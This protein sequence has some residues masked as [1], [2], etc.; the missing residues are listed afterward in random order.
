MILGLIPTQYVE[1]IDPDTSGW[2]V[3]PNGRA[4]QLARGSRP[5]DIGQPQSNRL[6]RGENIDETYVATQNA[7]RVRN[8]P[9]AGR[10]GSSAADFWSEPGSAYNAEYPFNRVIE[11]MSGDSV[12]EIDDTPGAERIMVYHKSGSYVQIDVNGTTTHKATSDKYEVNERNQHVYVGGKSVVTIE[13]DSYVLVRGNKVEEIEGDY[14]QLIRGNH[15]I[16]VAGQA[17]INA[18]EAVQIRAAKIAIESN[19][20]NM[21]LLSRKSI[22]L[23]ANGFRIGPTGASEGISLKASLG[24]V[25]IHAPARNVNISAGFNTR[26][27]ALGQVSILGGPTVAID[28]GIISL[29]NGLAAAIPAYAYAFNSPFAVPTA[30]PEPVAKSVGGRP[31]AN[32]ASIGTV[33]YGSKDEEGIDFSIPT[34]GS[35]LAYSDLERLASQSGFNAEEARIMAAIALAESSGNTAAFNGRG[36]DQSYG[37]WQINMIGNL[38]PARRSQFGIDSDQDLFDPSTNARAAFQVYRERQRITSSGDGFTAWS[39]YTNGSYKQ[40][41]T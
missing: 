27:Q 4:H 10:D 34:D 31:N 29:A 26:I 1:P 16:S 33:G 20:G 8:I 25:N 5:R 24:S 7:G 40:Y 13:G 36:P 9:I 2:G 35:V 28:A 30:M 41:L 14:T 3:I 11:S 22:S 32:H 12:I 23:T 19:V 17:N 15:M 37:L 38:G 18:S 6:V 21:S 39:V